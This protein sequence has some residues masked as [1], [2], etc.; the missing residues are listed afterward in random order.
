MVAHVP[1]DKQVADILTKLV[2][3]KI[4]NELVPVVFLIK[5]R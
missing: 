2:T 3:I 5:L 4:I 1:E